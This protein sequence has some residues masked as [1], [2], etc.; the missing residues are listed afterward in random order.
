MSFTKKIF[1]AGLSISVVA[2]LLVS[3]QTPPAK[4]ANNKSAELLDRSGFQTTVDSQKTDL[5]ILRNANGMVATFTNYG[6]R[7]VSLQV[8]DKNGKMVNVVCGFKSIAEY[9]KATEPYYGATIGRFGNRIA[10]GRFTLN[11]KQYQ[12]FLNNGPNTLHG[13]KKGFQYQVFNATQPDSSTVVF[14]RVSKDME[15]GFPGNLTVKVTYHLNDKNGLEMAYEAT[16]DKPTVVNL[17]NH[18]FFNLNGEGSGIIL[19]HQFQIFASHYTPVDSTLI[20]TGEI[21]SVVNT[22]FDFRAP[23]TMG[24]RIDKDNQQLKNCKG[25]DINFVLDST[26]EWHLAAIVDGD[27]SGIEMSVYTDQ[28]GLQIY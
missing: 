3:C 9:Q 28:P 2:L 22:P 26:N 10:K 14:T 27:R 15:E 1:S 7:L 4:T 6:G 8:P 19:N 11:G 17:T 21:E 23:M 12:L 13:G 16:T 5:Y 18:G 24:A 25:Y 20:P